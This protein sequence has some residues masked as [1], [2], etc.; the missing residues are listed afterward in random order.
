MLLD[1]PDIQIK[2]K[3]IKLLVLDV[4][5]VL[6]DGKLY[7]SDTGREIKSFS[8]LDGHGIKLLRKTGVE[9]GI[10]TGRESELVTKRASDLGIPYLI[11]GREDKYTAL[12][13]MLNEYPCQLDEICYVGDDHPDLLVMNK[14]GLAISVPNAHIDVIERAHGITE[15]QGGHGAVREVCDLIMHAQNTYSNVVA[16]YF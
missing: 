4:D 1:N 7:F 3:K 6:S 14:I 2:A 5:G 8:T 9:V 13:E 12:T 11:Q 15:K 10:I 16:Q